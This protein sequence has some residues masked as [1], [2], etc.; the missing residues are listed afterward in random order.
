MPKISIIMN[1]Y[2][3]EA[4]LKEA[5]DSVYAQTYNDW[6][7]I[8]WDNQSTDSS[9]AIAKSYDDRLRYFCG[10]EFLPLSAARNKALEKVQGEYI[11]FLD[12][13]DEW[14]PEKLEQQIRIFEQQPGVDFIYGSFYIYNTQLKTKQLAFKK[15]QPSGNIFLLQASIGY[16]IGLLTVMFKTCLL[17]N[18]REWV[19]VNICIPADLDFF[20]RILKTAKAYYIDEP[21]AIYRIHGSSTTR[22]QGD[23]HFN[24]LRYVAEKLIDLYGRESDEI[25]N[26]L[27][28]YRQDIDMLEAKQCILE[29]NTK[30]AAQLFGKYRNSDRKA[31]ILYL[32]AKLPGRISKCLYNSYIK[33]RAILP[34]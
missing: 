9:A 23:D 1:C 15:P 33:V 16:S 27:H 5:I 13:D 17:A 20:L 26:A 2:N 11:A 32:L 18:I 25:N 8:F 29:C 12:A 22:T 14:L 28:R 34:C 7:I 21:V 10:D 31:G 30:R 4:Y 6:E 19:D 3:S 24:D